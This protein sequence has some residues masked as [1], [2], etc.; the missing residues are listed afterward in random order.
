MNLQVLCSEMGCCGKWARM[1]IAVVATTILLVLVGCAGSS[2]GTIGSANGIRT[3]VTQPRANPK[4]NEAMYRANAQRTGEYFTQSLS[5]LSGFLWDREVGEQLSSALLV[6]DGIVYFNMRNGYLTGLNAKTAEGTWQTRGYGGSPALID[7]ILY[8]SWR[9][10]HAL[11]VK[12]KQEKWQFDL[13]DDSQEIVSSPAV[14]DGVVFFGSGGGYLYALGQ[15]TGQEQWKFKAGDR[16]DS[17]PAI[18]DGNVYFSGATLVM[19]S[20]DS[21]V[22]EGTLYALD[23]RTGQEKWSFKPK[24]GAYSPVIGGNIIYCTGPLGIDAGPDPVGYVY[25][26]DSTTGKEKWRYL[27]EGGLFTQL[28]YADGIV[29]VGTRT[30]NLVAID[31]TGP[32]VLW[33]FKAGD[34]ISSA[35]SIA[36]G[37]V[38]LSSGDRYIYALDA[39]TGQ[40]LWRIQTKLVVRTPPVIDNGVVYVADDGHNVYAI[41]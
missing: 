29:Y 27:P 35:P 10:L 4:S 23:A 17:D 21:G 33:T 13:Q 28:A 5:K 32:Q 38:Y 37:V 26:L 19:D 39:L 36:G 9:E 11:D 7:G 18:A 8:Y 15:S 34:F 41:H 2:S 3:P 40:N 1:V 12:T 24:G 6:A 22:Y 20:S 31:S 14:V 30:G 16:V 25:A